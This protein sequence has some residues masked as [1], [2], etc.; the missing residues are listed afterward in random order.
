M[1]KIR[2]RLHMFSCIVNFFK[3]IN[4][5]HI[6]SILNFIFTVVFYTTRW[7]KLDTVCICFEKF[8]NQFNLFK[9]LHIFIFSIRMRCMSWA[10]HQFFYRAKFNIVSSEWNF[11]I[12]L[13]VFNFSV[14][15]YTS[16][17]CVYFKLKKLIIIL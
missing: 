12:L 17:I 11:Y 9:Y 4:L 1:N 10:V 16:L 3:I 13:C 7:T 5:T 2:Y 14:I 6:I 15:F 8:I